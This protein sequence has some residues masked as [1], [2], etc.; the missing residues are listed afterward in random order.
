MVALTECEYMKTF[1]QS[2]LGVAVRVWLLETV[3]SGFN[4]FVLMQLVYQPLWGELVAHQVGMATRIVYIFVL[5]YLILRYT[6]RYSTQDLVHVGILWLV[7][8]EVFE[9]G[10]SFLL[11][12][13]VHDILI[14]WDIFQGYMWPYVLLSYLLAPLIVGLMLHP[15]VKAAHKMR[16]V[17]GPP[18]VT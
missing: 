4:F 18:P 12:R 2:L 7:L 5:A 17:Q 13:S 9:W 15:G 6:K 3:V 10:G 14:G 8:E 1:N 16:R 11:G